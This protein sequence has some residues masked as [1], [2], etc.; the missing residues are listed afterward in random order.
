MLK[1]VN[2]KQSLK[3]TKLSGGKKHCFFTSNIDVERNFRFTTESELKTPNGAANIDGMTEETN[4]N[5]FC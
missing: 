1:A 3:R 4:K 2:R 5:W